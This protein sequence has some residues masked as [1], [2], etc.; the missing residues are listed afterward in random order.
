[1]TDLALARFCAVWPSVW[2]LFW[3]GCAIAADDPARA[4]ILAVCALLHAGLV[5]VGLR[6]LALAHRR[7][8]RAAASRLVC[9]DR[10][11][12]QAWLAVWTDRAAVHGYRAPR[13]FA[14]HLGAV[15]AIACYEV[16]VAGLEFLP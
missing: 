2:L 9:R 3:L 7:E 13:T 15:R 12:A 1:M 11:R 4:A 6:T 5:L 10:L 14:A 16:A 8:A